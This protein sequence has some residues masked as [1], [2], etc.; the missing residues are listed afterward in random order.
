M[1]SQTQPPPTDIPATCLYLHGST[2]PHL[3]QYFSVGTACPRSQST[4]FRR[5]V[6]AGPTPPIAAPRMSSMMTTTTT[7][8]ATTAATTTTANFASCTCQKSRCLKLY[9]QCFSTS[10]TCTP[11]CRC[12]DC[13]NTEGNVDARRRAIKAIV[14]RNPGAFRPKF[15]RDLDPLVNN[16]YL[17]RRLGIFHG[18]PPTRGTTTTAASGGIGG[19]PGTEGI[20]GGGVVAHKIGCKCRKSACMKKYCECFGASTWCGPNCRCVGCMNDP[21]A[22]SRRSSTPDRTSSSSSWFES[23][24]PSPSSAAK[25]TFLSSSTPM[26]QSEAPTF[27]PHARRSSR[28]PEE[29][30]FQ[31]N[32]VLDPPIFP[33]LS[34]CTT[35]EM[36]LYPA[37]VAARSQ[38]TTRSMSCS[39]EDVDFDFGS[40]GIRSPHPACRREFRCLTFVR[41]IALPFFV[42]SSDASSSSSL[43]CPSQGVI[44]PPPVPAKSKGSESSTSRTACPS[45]RR[46]ATSRIVRYTSAAVTSSCEERRRSRKDDRAACAAPRRLLSTVGINERITS[47]AVRT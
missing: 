31:A 42:F 26:A 7:T 19:V 11:S 37:G 47:G 4:E 6:P 44:P 39:T 14:A 16:K 9:C 12:L 46:F 29:V 3:H 10:V 20:G 18:L 21:S 5:H 38:D 36:E 27:P 35:A 22:T 17:K 13:M 33:S 24:P 8:T 25:S 43:S 30:E 28:L 32:V 23:P 45:Y 15:V 40:V 34:N 41:A 1:S 2:H